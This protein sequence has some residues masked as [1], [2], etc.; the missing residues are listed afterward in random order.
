MRAH[1]HAPWWRYCSCL[2]ASLPCGHPRWGP[3]WHWSP[4]RH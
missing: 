1:I 2:L 3:G 4:C